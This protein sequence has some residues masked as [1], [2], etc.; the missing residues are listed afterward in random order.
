MNDLQEQMTKVMQSQHI[1]LAGSLNGTTRRKKM[2]I[3]QSVHLGRRPSVII[4]KEQWNRVNCMTLEWQMC[5][6]DVRIFM[7][8]HQYGSLDTQ[9][10]SLIE[11]TPRIKLRGFRK[12]R[13]SECGTDDKLLL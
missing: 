8:I 2:W 9:Y 1:I 6:T 12:R 10:S 7:G 11:R 5:S 4:D 3:T 13:A